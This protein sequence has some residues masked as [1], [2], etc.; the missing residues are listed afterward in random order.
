[1]N[2]NHRKISFFIESILELFEEILHNTLT[3]DYFKVI[4]LGLRG[5]VLFC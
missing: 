5:V 2:K 1:M 4:K 3:L